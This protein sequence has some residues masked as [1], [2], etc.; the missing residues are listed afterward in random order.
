[1]VFSKLFFTLL[2][3]TDFSSLDKASSHFILNCYFS[4]HKLVWMAG[5][6]EELNVLI[7][8]ANR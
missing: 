8:A 7:V 5:A 1:M 3:W 2:F 6:V 4:V